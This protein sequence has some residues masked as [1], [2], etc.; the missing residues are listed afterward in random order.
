MASY[1]SFSLDVSIT[2]D[3]S[4][5]RISFAAAHFGVCG[6]NYVESI[7]I[8]LIAS[9][10]ENRLFSANY[11]KLELGQTRQ[12]QQKLGPSDALFGLF[13]NT[14]LQNEREN[15][16]T[17]TPHFQHLRNSSIRHIFQACLREEWRE[18]LVTASWKGHYWL[19]YTVVAVHKPKIDV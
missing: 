3:A 4:S 16:I 12:P 10:R 15:H 14:D 8:K 11:H 6:M 13:L 9:P 17:I 5:I 19:R 1:F 18:A 2:T 7:Y